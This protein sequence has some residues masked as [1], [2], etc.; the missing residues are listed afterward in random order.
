[1]VKLQKDAIELKK[2]AREENLLLRKQEHE[3][4]AKQ[5]EAQLLTAEAGIMVVD[6]EKVAPHLKD[7]YIGMQREIMERRGFKSSSSNNA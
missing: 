4:L 1:V 5:T 7:Y 6:L 3:L 2:Q